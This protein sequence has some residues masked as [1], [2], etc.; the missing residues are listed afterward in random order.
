MREDDVPGRK[1]NPAEKVGI[2]NDYILTSTKV[3]KGMA[4]G[5]AVK[6][7]T[8]AVGTSGSGGEMYD[9]N[10]LDE[11]TLKSHLNQRVEVD[12]TFQNLDRGVKGTALVE[13]K[14][15]AIRAVQGACPR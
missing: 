12:G 6:R 15:T 4:P 10:G 2:G 9:V 11:A 3:T 1:A 14:A 7:E 13:I 5:S 8:E